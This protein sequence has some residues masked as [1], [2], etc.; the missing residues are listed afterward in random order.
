MTEYLILSKE[1][2]EKLIK[3]EIVIA[4]IGRPI[5]LCSREYYEQQKK[6]PE[7]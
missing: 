7:R 6:W 2:L 1:E 4:D 5:I 3:N